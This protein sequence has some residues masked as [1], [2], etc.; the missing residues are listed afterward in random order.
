M[1][2]NP[3][4]ISAIKVMKNGQIELFWLSKHEFLPKS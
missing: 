1:P 3:F 4:L 2:L